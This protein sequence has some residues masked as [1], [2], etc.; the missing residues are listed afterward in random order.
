[1][2]SNRLRKDVDG[3]E[4]DTLRRRLVESVVERSLR[5][6]R[7]DPE[8]SLRKLVDLGRD[9]AQGPGQQRF[10]AQVQRVLARK[11]CPYYRLAQD[12]ATTVDP[13][14]LQT[15]GINLGWNGLTVGARQIR[16]LE[17]QLERHIPWSLTLC[18]S[19]APSFAPV[20]ARRL[21]EGRALGIRV[22]F[23]FP[24]DRPGA[25]EQAVELAGQAGDCVFFLFLPPRWPVDALARSAADHLILG[26]D[27][28]APGWQADAGT[29][30]AAGCLYLLYRRYDTPAEAEDICSGRW[31]QQL[32][33]HGGL[34]AVC[35]AGPGC[36]VPLC[37]QVYRSVLC[38]R[39]NPREPILPAE[40]RL[41]N[42][43][44]DSC[45]SPN[46]CLLR[47]G[48]DSADE[49]LIQSLPPL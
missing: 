3:M 43:S 47:L 29:L 27:T 9:L 39:L 6:I 11:G 13:S 41:D 42:L 17:P 48:P 14:R 45:V 1:M 12:L 23:L 40:F 16:A 10:F 33:T 2:V 37:R 38:A 36:P 49:P 30:R 44:A 8:R 28:A 26:V 25:V 5:S 24:Q 31:A 21:A 32:R 22:Y 35:V 18:L 4:Q 19:G 46:P 34:A 15:V 20:C 7:T